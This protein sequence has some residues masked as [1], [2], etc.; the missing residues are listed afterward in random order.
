MEV[1][2][3]TILQALTTGSTT[4]TTGNSYIIIPDLN[5]VYYLKINLNSVVEDI[6][7]F[8]AFDET[9]SYSGNTNYGI[10][11]YLLNNN[12]I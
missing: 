8:D 7:F 5:A 10:N 4:G 12:F 9:Y 1:L 3:K 6:G 11:E 2:Q